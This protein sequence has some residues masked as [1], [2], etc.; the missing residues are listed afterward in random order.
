[1][2]L[3]LKKRR[4]KELEF[5]FIS[6]NSTLFCIG[7]I[8]LILQNNVQLF[9]GYSK[10]GQIKQNAPGLNRGLSSNFWWLRSANHVKFTE[11]CM[12]CS[13]VKL[14]T[15]VEGDLKAPFSIATTPGGG[16][17][18]LSHD[19]STLPLIH[20]LYCWVL[21]KEVT[22]T[23]FKV[24]GMM[25]PGIEPR[26]P[27]PLANTLPPRS[28]CIINVINKQTSHNLT[29]VDRKKQRQTDRWFGCFIQWHISFWGLFNAKAIL[30][31][32]Q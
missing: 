24:F 4:K 1:M 13:K 26:S 23:I 5:F 11:E 8:I 15:V 27:G 21:S 31:E 14:V 28:M 10:W 19:C 18:L 30:V 2:E 12:M 3:F 29:L 25:R 20:T 16:V 6:V 9:W 22:S 32:V 7:D 17:L